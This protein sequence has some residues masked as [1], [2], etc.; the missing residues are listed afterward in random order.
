MKQTSSTPRGWLDRGGFEPQWSTE[1][2]AAFFRYSPLSGKIEGEGEQLTMTITNI[3]LNRFVREYHFDDG[4]RAADVV[5]FYAACVVEAIERAGEVAEVLEPGARLI[6]RRWESSV[7][8]AEWRGNESASAAA[9]RL[10]GA[11]R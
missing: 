2:R 5:P 8:I 6:L 7:T 4:V 9:T 10:E 11:S 3:N 1:E